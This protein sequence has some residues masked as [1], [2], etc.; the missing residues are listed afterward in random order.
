MIKSIK[1]LDVPIKKV[2]KEQF[3][4]LV[5]ETIEQKQK[6]QIA[7]VNAE[8]LVEAQKDQKLFKILQSSFNITDN[9]GILW[10]SFFLTCTRAFPKFLRWL[11]K[12]ILILPTLILT[13]FADWI[14]KIIPERLAG[15]DIFWDL[16]KLADK[17][18]F[19]IFLLGAG[20][21]VARQTAVIL[22]NKFPEL[23][24][25]GAEMGD[26]L[27]PEILR[28]K[29]NQSQTNLLFVAYGAPKQEKWIKENLGQ[30]NNGLV[31]I[32]VGGTFDFV[33]GRIKRAPI[34]LRKIGL[35]WLY[36]LIQEPKKRFKR[37]INAVFVFPW[38]TLI[39]G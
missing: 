39:K 18:N 25:V 13:L 1:I 33:A 17:N 29:I 26:D 24:I 12:I 28:N 21:N 35:E 14:Y 32:G 20:P 23:N 37:I 15:A 34:W 31:A 30:L 11:P 8:F 5:E 2:R 36:R 7:T 16:I 27:E 10:A 22:K 3:L 4:S 6:L 19:N 38:L 9:V